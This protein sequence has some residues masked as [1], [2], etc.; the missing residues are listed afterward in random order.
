MKGTILFYKKSFLPK[1]TY[2]NQYKYDWDLFH[3]PLDDLK[4]Q[5]INNLDD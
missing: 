4:I 3:Y 5:D 2:E 1:Q